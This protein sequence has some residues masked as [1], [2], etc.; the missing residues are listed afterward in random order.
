[1]Q[2]PLT[3]SGT[4]YMVRLAA[5]WNETPESLILLD[6]WHLLFALLLL[7]VIAGRHWIF[8]PAWRASTWVVAMGLGLM[9][10]RGVL[11]LPPFWFGGLRDF[12]Y[13]ALQLAPMM[14]MWM[15]LLAHQIAFADRQ[16][17][18]ASNTA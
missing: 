16:S 8:S 10:A 14:L 1:M 5:E 13:A 4:K 18:I 11:S 12:S 17:R 3:I 7:L 6:N 15:A 2:K 9:V